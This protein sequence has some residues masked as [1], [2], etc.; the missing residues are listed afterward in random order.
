MKIYY[1][2]DKV[3]ERPKSLYYNG[4]TYVPPTDELLVEAGYKIV[5]TS[6][7]PLTNA[8][9]KVL[10]AAEYAA[11]ADQHFL[12]YQAYT[13]L[14]NTEKAEQE[15]KIW[16]EVRQAIDVE[17]PYVDESQIVEVEDIV[18][19]KEPETVIYEEAPELI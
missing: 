14:G 19:E 16:L 4:R 10:R 7:K 1:K 12:A 15:K 11:R 5:I 17:L 9:I 18:L 2:N 13:E 3:V 8:D 6:P